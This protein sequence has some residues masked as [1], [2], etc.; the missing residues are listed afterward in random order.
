MVAFSLEDSVI[1]LGRLRSCLRTLRDEDVFLML[2]DAIERLSPEDLE[3]VVRPLLEPER[4]RPSGAMLG[5]A[6][7]IG[8]VRAFANES[9]AGDYYESFDV[10]SRNYT[11]TPSSLCVT[12]RRSTAL[13]REPLRRKG[14]GAIGEC[15][16]HP[17]S[18]S[19]CPLDLEG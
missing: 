16:E 4:L 7:L 13:R 3:Q 8:Q 11:K 14:N 15:P 2:D 18:S 6:D 17:A 19:S 10:T 1:D 12:T 5:S 9:N